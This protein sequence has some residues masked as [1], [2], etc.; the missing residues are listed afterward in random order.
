MTLFTRTR[1]RKKTGA[2]KEREGK[3]KDGQ[4]TLKKNKE[5][6]EDGHGTLTSGQERR[7]ALV[8]KRPLPRA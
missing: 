1:E 3:N 8:V 2:T 7:P 5:E 6:E 4:G